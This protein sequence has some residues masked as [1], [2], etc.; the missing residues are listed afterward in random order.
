[1]ERPTL[2][3]PAMTTR[4]SAPQVR[5]VAE[6]GLDDL[7]VVLAQQHVHEV[8]L[9]HDGVPAWEHLRHPAG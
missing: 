4:I 3:A 7:H 8:S 5:R 6:H 9:L 1:M 2:P